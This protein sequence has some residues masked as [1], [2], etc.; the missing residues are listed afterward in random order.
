MRPIVYSTSIISPSEEV[1]FGV[2]G[3]VTTRLFIAGEPFMNENCV[4]YPCSLHAKKIKLHLT[5]RLSSIDFEET[6][7]D[8]HL[9][10]RWEDMER[11]MLEAM[12]R[13]FLAYCVSESSF[14]LA[15]PSAQSPERPQAVC[16]MQLRPAVFPMPPTF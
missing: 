7:K 14:T 3:N 5:V 11:F 1:A 15:R 8:H 16:A 13:V 2:Y 9:R 4:I 12:K 10:A 6:R